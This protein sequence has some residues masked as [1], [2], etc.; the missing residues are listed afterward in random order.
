SSQAEKPLL[1]PARTLIGRSRVCD[2]QVGAR[3]VSAQHAVLEWTGC[4]WELRDLQSRNGT[5]VDGQQIAPGQRVPLRKGQHVRFA[6]S[7]EEWTLVDETGPMPMARNLVNGDVIQADNG[8][9]LLPDGLIVF[10]EATGQWF[11]EHDGGDD[12]SAVVDR[13]EL[14]AGGELWRLY[15]SDEN[16]GTQDSGTRLL[17]LS[18]TAWTFAHSRD[19]EIVEIRI[20]AGSYRIELESHA[21]HYPLLLLARARLEHQEAGFPPDEQG[22]VGR[23]ELLNMLKIDRTHL[24]ISFHRARQQLVKVGVLDPEGL[25]ERRRRHRQLRLGVQAKKTVLL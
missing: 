16:I 25:I 20:S 21:Y 22:W 13:A 15:L 10:K 14:A 23:D 24:N 17:K 3:D 9:L 1:L 2:C 19:E 11:E 18:E 7:S 4:I 6:G 5:F 8:L 12:A